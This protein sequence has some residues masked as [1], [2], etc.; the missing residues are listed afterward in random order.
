MAGAARAGGRFRGLLLPVLANV[1]C[2]LALLQAGL[3]VG[4]AGAQAAAAA[5]AVTHHYK[6]KAEY[7]YWSPDCVES[8]IIAVNGQYPA[9]TI[10][11][12]AGDT[13]VVELENA[14]PT[15]GLAIHWHGMLQVGCLGAGSQTCFFKIHAYM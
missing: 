3:L 2:V 9:P 8:V 15:E 6:W 1:V 14:L 5:H 10:R 11:V 4:G 12:R 7:V 13:V